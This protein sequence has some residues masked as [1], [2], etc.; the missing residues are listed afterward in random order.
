MKILFGLHLR[1]LFFGLFS[2][3]SQH[4]GH[5]EVGHKWS[6][7]LRVVEVD[8]MIA[9]YFYHLVLKDRQEILTVCND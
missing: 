9:W 3:L 4:F 6:D 1:G 5:Q 8:V 2:R 7:Y